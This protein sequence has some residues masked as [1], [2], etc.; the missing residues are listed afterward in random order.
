MC[1]NYTKRYIH[2]CDW[3][4]ENQAYRIKFQLALERYM[5]H[6]NQAKDKDT[7]GD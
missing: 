4:C 1:N 6:L 5:I 2:V 7:A 3:I